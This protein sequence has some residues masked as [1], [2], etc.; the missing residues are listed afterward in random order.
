MHTHAC[1]H[2]VIKYLIRTMLLTVQEVNMHPVIVK[3]FF[4]LIQVIYTVHIY[5]A[6]L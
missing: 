3:K 2:T 5:T 1:A 4:A 6:N